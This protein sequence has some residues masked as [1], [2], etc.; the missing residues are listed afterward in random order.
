MDRLIS[1]LR[2]GPARWIVVSG[3]IGTGKSTLISF[4]HDYFKVKVFFEPNEHNPFLKKFYQDMKKWAFYSQV[5][6]LIKKFEL[7]LQMS[8]S[9]E[10]CILDRTIYE[11]AEVFART[12]NRS[13]IMSD[14]EFAKYNLL[15]TTLASLL[16]P[17]DLMIYLKC[18][19]ATIMKRIKAR[20]RKEEQT[21]SESYIKMLNR[22]YNRW[23]AQYNLSP[24]IVLRTD[25]IDFVSDIVDQMDI[26]KMVAKVL[27][28][29]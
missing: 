23:L 5:F 27:G 3:N 14:E 17:P 29:V 28:R 11:D 12:L 1:G 16:K 24:V 19:T 9:E 4:L 15:Y 2:L 21:V 22:A 8:E 18:S 7:H 6:F 13:G 10:P 26:L 20:G 25:R